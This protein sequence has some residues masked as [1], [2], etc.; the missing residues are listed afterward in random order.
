LGINRNKKFYVN[1]PYM[2]LSDLRV[3]SMLELV[4]YGRGGQGAWTASNILAQAALKEGKYA[5]SFPTFGPERMGAPVMAFTRIS[6]EPIEL[7]CNIYEPDV[8]VVLDDSLLQSLNVTEGLKSEGKVIINS[9]EDPRNIIKMLRISGR[10]TVY[11]TPA[12]EI[13]L[14]ILGRPITNTAMIGG[15]LRAVE[16]VSLDSVKEVL[17][18][19]FSAKVAELN[20]KV[21]ERA[22]SETRGVGGVE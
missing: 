11:T 10:Q 4:W 15:L 12:T 19:R 16:V 8:V 13:A 7:H 5:Q 21:V 2:C 18:E 22:Y 3:R 20:I 6:D 9:K 14:E 1:P 17:R